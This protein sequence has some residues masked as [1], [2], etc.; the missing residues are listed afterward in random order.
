MNSVMIKEKT[1]IDR[2]RHIMIYW[3]VCQSIRKRTLSKDRI[4]KQI[5][6]M[7]TRDPQ[8]ATRF[9]ALRLENR[10]RKDA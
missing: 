1:I 3:N 10:A 5:N 6:F 2:E 8:L 4:E 9:Y 7:I